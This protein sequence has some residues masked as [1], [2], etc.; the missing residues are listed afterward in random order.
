M[1]ANSVVLAEKV[2]IVE[3]FGTEQSFQAASIP[4]LSDTFR[5]IAH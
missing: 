1:V 3:N 2:Q 5:G 4:G